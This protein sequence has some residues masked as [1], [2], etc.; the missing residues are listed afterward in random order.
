MFCDSHIN[1]NSY[2]SNYVTVSLGI[3]DCS[4][5]LIINIHLYLPNYFVYYQAAFKI[6]GLSKEK[7]TNLKNKNLLLL[8]DGILEIPFDNEPVKITTLYSIQGTDMLSANQVGCFCFH[9]WSW[10]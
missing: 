9:S 5:F 7:L 1:D 10:Y 2:K 8:K 3:A 4:I 6:R